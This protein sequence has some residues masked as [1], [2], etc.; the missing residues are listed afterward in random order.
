M[1]GDERTGVSIMRAHRR[2][3]QRAVCLQASEPIGPTDTYG[4]L[5]PRLQRSAASCSSRRST[6]GRRAAEQDDA[7]ATYA[8]KIDRRGPRAR[9]GPV[10]RP[11]SSASCA[12]CTPHIGAHVA[13]ADGDAARAVREARVGCAAVGR[14]PGPASWSRATGRCR[15]SAAPRGRSSCSWSSRPG[16]RPMSGDAYLRGRRC[17][18]VPAARRQRRLAGPRVRLRGRAAGVRAGRL[19]RPRA[20]TPRPRGST[21]RDRALAMALAYGTVQRARDARPR[22]RRGSPARPPERARPAGAGG[23]AARAVPAAATSAASPTTPRSTRASSS[24]SARGRGG[25][26]A[27]QRGAAPGGPRGRRRCSPSSTTTTPRARRGPAL[28]PAVARRAVVGRARRRARRARCCARVNEPAESAL[29]VNTLRSDASTR[30]RARAARR[31][32][33]TRRRCPRALVARGPFDAHGSALWPR[34]AIM[35]QSR[36]LDARRARARAAARRARARPL[37]RARRQD[38]APGRADGGPGRGRRASSATP[39]APQ[40]LRANLRADARERACSVEVG[41]RRGAARRRRPYD[42]VLVDPP[43][44][45]LGTLQSR[46]DLR[47][48]ATPERDRASSPRCRPGSSRPA[49]AATAP[50]GTLVYSVCTISRRRERGRSS[51]RFLREHPDF[52]RRRS[53]RADSPTGATPR[54]AL[55]AAAAA[56]RRHRRVLHRPAARAGE[57]PDAR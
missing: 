52:A 38:H 4:T 36:G 26:G 17:C 21:P 56:P 1:A 32:A 27:R 53:R 40:A 11:S 6:S 5:A 12:R 39:A 50:G 7:L 18:R 10:R 20:R 29:R 35:P 47:W 42:R 9:P 41:R 45:G 14:R 49:A 22:R 13:L 16:G 8:E 30:R 24:P 37:R 15:C 31:G 57:R 25:A 19:R 54:W 51:T 55:S 23:A 28:G 43:C 2:P 3:R 34:G 44:S 46:P 48:R 33:S